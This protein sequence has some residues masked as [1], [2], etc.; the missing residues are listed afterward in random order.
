ML[1]E[2]ALSET[3]DNMTLFAMLLAALCHDLDHPGVT[4]ALLSSCCSDLACLYNDV[5]VLEN[6]HAA[7]AWEVRLCG[8]VA[9]GC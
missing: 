1:Q 3:F 5:S 6:H 9:V 8:C 2:C 4:N 7:V